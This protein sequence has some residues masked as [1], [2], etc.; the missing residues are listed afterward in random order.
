M[1]VGL[2][3]SLMIIKLKV[4][5]RRSGTTLNKGKNGFR[6]NLQSGLD[7]CF[8]HK[9]FQMYNIK[10]DIYY[11]LSRRFLYIIE[12]QCAIPNGKSLKVN[13]I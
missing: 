5:F 12:T 9:D 8:M 13:I 2:V 6:V 7:H 10:N 3:Y 11:P 1:I 4:S